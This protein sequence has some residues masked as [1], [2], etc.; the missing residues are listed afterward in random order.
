LEIDDLVTVRSICER[1]AEPFLALSTRLDEETDFRL[2]EAGERRTTVAEQRE[3]IQHVRATENQTILVAEADG[4]LVGY[5]AGIGGEH[6]RNRHSVYVVVA[7]LQA[8]SGR[9][10]GTRLFQALETWAV[11]H[12]IHR[13]EL[14]VMMH[15][16]RAIGLYEKLG[17]RREGRKRDALL[18][19]GEYADEYLMAKLLPERTPKDGLRATPS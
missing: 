13:L 8:F 17:F 12:A 1:D 5:I 18:V 10:I 7:V 6:G 16:E 2:L 19:G 3:T 14:T 15:N 11:E 4:Q 9:G